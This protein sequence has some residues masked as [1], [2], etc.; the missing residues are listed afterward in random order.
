MSADN[1]KKNI[2]KAILSEKSPYIHF[3]FPNY[4]E[5]TGE[6]NL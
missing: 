3:V 5:A 1:A 2:Y 6:F 4:Q